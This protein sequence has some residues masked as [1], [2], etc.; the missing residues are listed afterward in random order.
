MSSQL[1][2]L[3]GQTF[4]HE[5]G[6]VKLVEDDPGGIISCTT[7]R[8]KALVSSFPTRL[9]SDH[10]EFI[11][12]PKQPRNRRYIFTG[13]NPAYPVFVQR[14]AIDPAGVSAPTDHSILAQDFSFPIRPIAAQLEFVC[15]VISKGNRTGI[16]T[17]P[18]P[19]HPGSNLSLRGNSTAF[20]PSLDA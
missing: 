11:W 9:V 1:S 4:S 6:F 13:A 16:L 12:S 5:P 8:R 20:R 19:A 15:L 2:V 3:P 17:G 10:L 7:H 18:N 14:L